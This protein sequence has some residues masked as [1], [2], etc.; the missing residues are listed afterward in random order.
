MAITQA[1]L[2][3]AFNEGYYGYKMDAKCPYLSTGSDLTLKNAWY[4][5]KYAAQHDEAPTVD[6]L[7]AY[8]AGLGRQ[9]AQEDDAVDILRRLEAK[10]D[11]ILT[12]LG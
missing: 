12:K 2:D 1:M 3:V 8:M 11:Q 5:G 10:L 6:D 4:R 9:N 7:D